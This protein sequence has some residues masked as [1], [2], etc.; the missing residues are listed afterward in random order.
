MFLE[1]W[2]YVL[3]TRVRSLLRRTEADQE[4]DEELTY[5][6]DQS[7]EAHRAN[8]LSPAE[9]RRQARLRFGG[10]ERTREEARD[11]RGLRLLEELG[12][13]VRIGV[14]TLLR[15]PGFAVSVILTLAIGIGA[16]AAVF[17]VVHAVLL[18]PFAYPAHE[19]DRVLLMAERSARGNRSGVSYPTFRDWVEQL[20]SFESLCGHVDLSFTLTGDQVA[21]PVRVRGLV[22]SPTYFGIHGIQPLHGRLYDASDDRFG[23]ARV[24]VLTHSLWQA[25]FGARA[26]VVGETIQLTGTGFTVVGVLPP[27]DLNPVYEIYT[28][29]EPLIEDFEGMQDRAAHTLYVHGRLRAD[30][31]FEQAKAELAGTAARFE[32]E[33]P[34]TNAGV[35]VIAAVPSM[36]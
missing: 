18:R 6:L 26:D 13:D 29:V 31:T 23:A 36:S 21:D 1:R 8:G 22:T 24:V 33:Y 16:T 25:A 20:E 32:T 2:W 9:A 7:V 15:R 12:R 11:A 30:V 28:P 27:L 34:E 4:L 14:R 10:I 5:H 35:E 3:T 17:S 19:P